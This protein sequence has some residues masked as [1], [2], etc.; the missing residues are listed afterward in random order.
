VG[1]K[2]EKRLLTGDFLLDTP[3]ARAQYASIHGLTF[4]RL[5]KTN[6]IKER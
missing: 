6:P 1:L 2:E 5:K 3:I 4:K